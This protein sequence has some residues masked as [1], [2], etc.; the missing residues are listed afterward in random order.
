MT[1]DSWRD[2]VFVNALCLLAFVIPF[3]YPFG[4]TSVWVLVLAWLIQ[5]GFANKFKRLSKPGYLVW[6]AYFILFALSYFYSKN[7]EASLLD[8]TT[9]LT[10]VIFPIL[11]GTVEIDRK[12]LEKIFNSFIAGLC[13]IAFFCILYAFC[14]FQKTGDASQFFYHAL[15]DILDAANAVYM[16]FYV[17]FAL[18]LF[19]TFRF[20]SVFTKE[21]KPFKWSVFGFLFAFFIM[22][23][24]RLLIFLF[25]VYLGIIAVKFLLRNP[26]KYVLKIVTLAFVVLTFCGFILFTKNPIKERYLLVAKGNMDWVRQKDFSNKNFVLD[27]V[28]VRLLIWRVAIENIEERNLWWKGCGNGD[29]NDI[30]NEKFVQLNVPGFRKDDRYESPLHSIYIHNMYLQSLEMIGIP[31]LLCLLLILILPFFSIK[32]V[33]NKGTFYIFQSTAILFMMQESVLQIQAGIIYF[34]FFSIVFWSFCYSQKNQKEM[35]RRATV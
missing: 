33:K 15:V 32:Y 3:P 30:Q 5:G 27:N 22:L 16:S 17:I 13:A 12:T 31:G 14:I 28:N 26:K 19:I 21:R 18:F 24:C 9:K 20:S 4:A 23:A 35:P 10:F 2:K 8:L 34:T 1:L 11:I 25:L 29:I 6:I 7:K